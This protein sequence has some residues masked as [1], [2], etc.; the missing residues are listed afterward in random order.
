M[1]F[2]KNR[3]PLFRDMRS[4]LVRAPY[5]PPPVR[6]NGRSARG[7]ESRLSLRRNDRVRHSAESW[8]VS[9][10]SWRRC[11]E[12]LNAIPASFTSV[13]IPIQLAMIALAALLGWA[14]AAYLRRRLDVLPYIVGW[15]TILR[16][17]I[18]V[19]IA[20]LGII[21]CIVILL[22][23][24][25]GMQRRDGARPLL[26][27]RRRREP[28]DRLGRHRHRREPDPQRVHQPRG[29]GRRV[30]DRGA[31]HRRAARRGHRR[32]RPGRHRHRRP[33]GHRAAGAQDRRAAAAL[34]LGRGRRSATS[35]IRG[36]GPTRT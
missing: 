35:S 19:A 17:A 9:T 28:R 14:L 2:S 27:D 23:M 24:R 15:P 8:K 29:V 12:Q 7:P 16:R 13:W 20:N 30:V 1:S 11:R 32:A 26:P 21:I 6:L 10:K 33:A 34:A 22:L 31:E 25:I 18:R 5:R 36:C 3:C 4:P